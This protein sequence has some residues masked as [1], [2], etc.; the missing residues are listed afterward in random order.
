MKI[1][2]SF[3]IGL[4]AIGFN[5]AHAAINSWEQLQNPGQA[6]YEIEDTTGNG[7]SINCDTETANRKFYGRMVWYYGEPV[8]ATNAEDN[9]MD[10][11]V[12]GKTYNIPT[13]DGS[14]KAELAWVAF[15]NAIGNAKT[16]SVNINGNEAANFTV[17]GERLPET[18]FQNCGHTRPNK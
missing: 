8:G 11:V 1:F 12:N 16:F 17:E 13:V 3:L 15:V 18:F 6:V 10:I 7:L 9:T 2:T 5:T 14:D 4:F